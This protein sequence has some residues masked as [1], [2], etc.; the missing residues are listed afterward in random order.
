MLEGERGLARRAQPKAETK[1][2]SAETSESAGGRLSRGVNLPALASDAAGFKYPCRAS[3]H[4]A[5]QGRKDDNCVAQLSADCEEERHGGNNCR[6]NGPREKHVKPILVLTSVR[7]GAAVHD[8]HEPF[9]IFNGQTD[10][11]GCRADGR[12]VDLPRGLP[13]RDVRLVGG[14]H[15]GANTQP[16]KLG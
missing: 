8:C 1:S 10:D 15:R 9:R 7:P 2:A 6:T 5:G 14:R 3:V 16:A 13:D 4:S 12:G 11:D